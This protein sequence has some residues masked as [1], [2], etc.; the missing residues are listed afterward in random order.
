MNYRKAQKQITSGKS[1][2]LCDNDT[3]KYT[4]EPIGK[5]LVKRGRP[6]LETKPHWTDRMKCKICGKEYSR[7]A[8]TAHSK[9]NHHKTYAKFNDKIRNLMLE[10]NENDEVIK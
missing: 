9:T 8:V 7:S 5:A 6:P 1:L 3:I 10:D 2:V 4:K